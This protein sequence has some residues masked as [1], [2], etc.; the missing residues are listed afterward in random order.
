MK[1]HLAITAVMLLCSALFFVVV[2]AGAD[3]KGNSNSS[4][5]VPRPFKATWSGAGNF[6]PGDSSCP[7]GAIVITTAKGIAT[8]TGASEFVGTYCCNLT[9][10]HCTGTGV[11]TAANGDALYFSIT[12]DFNPATGDFTESEDYTGGT[13]R[14][15]GATGRSTTSGTATFMTPTSDVWEGTTEGEIL[16]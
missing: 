10:G 7:G 6:L 11:L 12:H 14:F 8:L 13:G 2:C 3:L 5:A 15:V 1:R 4:A 16:F 9:T